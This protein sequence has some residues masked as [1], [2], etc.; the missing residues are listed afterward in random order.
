MARRPMPAGDENEEGHGED[1]VQGGS[2][3][4]VPGIGEIVEDDTY[5]A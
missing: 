2:V 5:T 3:V 4:R 1:Y